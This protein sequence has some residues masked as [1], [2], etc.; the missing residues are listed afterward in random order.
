MAWSRMKL[1]ALV[2]GVVLALAGVPVG[3]WLSSF[4]ALYERPCEAELRGCTT[5][6][7]YRIVGPAL[8][9]VGLLALAGLLATLLVALARGA[10]GELRAWY[11]R[12]GGRRPSD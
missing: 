9:L 6:E 7:F 3:L 8:V 2:A 1:M 5:W 4:A 12:R 10:W 11:R